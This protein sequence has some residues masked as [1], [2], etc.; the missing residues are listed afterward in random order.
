MKQSTLMEWGSYWKYQEGKKNILHI[1]ILTAL[2]NFMC[3]SV[4]YPY[5]LIIMKVTEYSVYFNSGINQ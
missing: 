3:V 5:G 4:L 1:F 2:Y